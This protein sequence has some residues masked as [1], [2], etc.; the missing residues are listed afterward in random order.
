MENI[1][2]QHKDKVS[3]I[4]P[5]HRE[6]L[7]QVLEAIHNSTYKNIEIIVVDEGK[8]RSTQRNIGIKRATGR[9]LFI[10]DSDQVISSRL[11]EEC[12]EK[13]EFGIGGMYIP[14]IIKTKGIFAYIRNWERQF[15]KG[16]PIDCVRFV[17]AKDCPLFDESM[18][19][20]E[21]S[22]WDRQI[23]GI[24]VVAKNPLYHYDNIGI[25]KYF[26]KK[27]YYS[28]SMARFTELYPNDKV[29]NWKWRCFGV[30]FE[31]GKWKKFLLRPD[32]AIAVLILIF[33]RGV[34]YKWNK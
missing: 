9:Y 23:K 20:P 16:S 30:F 10:L 19:G 7:A 5:R 13:M 3:I 27:A 15:Y 18:S 28:K 6:D 22:D 8:E 25:I 32:L 29:L 17:R 2:G 4:I 12:V 11:I 31:N 33:V 21:D 14:E 1:F 34:I 24:K 26:K